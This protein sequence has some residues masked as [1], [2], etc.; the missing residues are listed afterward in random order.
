MFK[1][2]ALLPQIF[3]WAPAVF[4]KPSAKRSGPCFC[5]HNWTFLH[6]TQLHLSLCV[7]MCAVF[8]CVWVCGCV[9]TALCV[10]SRILTWAICALYYWLVPC[11]RSRKLSWAQFW[12]TKPNDCFLK[13]HRMTHAGYADDLTKRD[14]YSHLGLQF[15]LFEKVPAHAD[16]L[17]KRLIYCFL[18][19]IC[20]WN[21]FS[22]AAL[23][24]N[25]QSRVSLPKRP[26]LTPFLTHFPFFV[27]FSF[28]LSYSQPG[29][30]EAHLRGC[31]KWISTKPQRDHEP[32]LVLKQDERHVCQ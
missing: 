30:Q 2:C 23:I 16:E 8:V 6:Q 20:C 10:C 5:S 31:N 22:V 27:S 15:I 4:S 13:Q 24:V 9:T 26:A 3:A 1:S 12:L 17:S 18:L 21:G 11:V 28:F 32:S 19:E 29:G 14:R 7:Y 25:L